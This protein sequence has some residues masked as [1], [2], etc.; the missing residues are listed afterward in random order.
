M[1]VVTF[2]VSGFCYEW[3]R[4]HTKIRAKSE[5]RDTPKT[6]IAESL[7]ACCMVGESIQIS[8]RRV[9]LSVRT[10]C[11]IASYGHHKSDKEKA[12]FTTQTSL[13]YPQRPCPSLNTL[14]LH[15]R[16]AEGLDISKRATTIVRYPTPSN[17]LDAK[18][19]QCGS[20]NRFKPPETRFLLAQDCELYIEKC[21]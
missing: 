17:I 4:K 15:A 21:I 10:G 8:F 6:G 14:P 13:V 5:K 19:H 18:E 12:Q 7:L 16:R 11:I 3:T 1:F 2:R 9:L 20:C